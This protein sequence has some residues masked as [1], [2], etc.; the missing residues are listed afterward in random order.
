M[1]PFSVQC[2][3]HF[4]S[5]SF[6]TIL[7]RIGDEGAPIVN[8]SFR[9]ASLRTSSMSAFVSIKP[10]RRF[11]FLRRIWATSLP[12]IEGKKSLRSTFSRKFLVLCR[13][14]FR[15]VLLPFLYALADLW[16]DKVGRRRK[17]GG[18]ALKRRP[19]TGEEKER[20]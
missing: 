20:V 13:P 18:D 7:E 5:N 1:T 17:V 15:L 11:I 14:A 12:R 6:I 19:Y 3:D 8:L 2:G 9:Q 10:S 16:V 4:A